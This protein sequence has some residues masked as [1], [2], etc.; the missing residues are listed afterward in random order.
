MQTGSPRAPRLNGSRYYLVG[1]IG[2]AQRGAPAL[3]LTLSY[4]LAR[5][6]ASLNLAMAVQIVA[7]ELRMAHLGE[8]TNLAEDAQWDTPF[9]TAE[10]VMDR[11]C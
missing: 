2:P 5:G 4:S 8:V 11:F 7:Y 1:R 10:A 6:M 9:A 3:S